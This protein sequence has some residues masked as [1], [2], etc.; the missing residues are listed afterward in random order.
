MSKG[1]YIARQDADDISVPS[2]FEKQ[3]YFLRNV[4]YDFCCSRT[5]V[6]DRRIVSPRYLYYL[7]FKFTL[8]FYNPFIH[9]TWMF[10]KNLIDSVGLYDESIKYAQDYDYISRII[11]AKKRV[12]YIKENLIQRNN[13]SNITFTKKD[14]QNYYSN[15][16]MIKNRK[17]LFY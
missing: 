10:K 4:K 8:L 3:V 14:K 5:Y 12:K 17:R 13:E 2:R 11:Y 7:P 16:I 6:K 9:G 1:K 15:K